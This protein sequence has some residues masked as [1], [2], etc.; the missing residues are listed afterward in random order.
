MFMLDDL[1]ASSLL[2]IFHSAGKRHSIF[3]L[4]YQLLAWEVAQSVRVLLK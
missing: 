2:A 4:N 1:E 3:I